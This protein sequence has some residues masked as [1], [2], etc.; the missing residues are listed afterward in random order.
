MNHQDRLQT[1]GFSILESAFE[2]RD[3]DRIIDELKVLPTSKSSSSR[4][5]RVFGARNLFQILPSLRSV[6]EAE[7]IT[8]WVRQLAGDQARS[9]RCLF[10]DKNPTANW[11]VGWHQDLTI[12]VRQRLP[13]E[14]F[15]PWTL[16]AGVPHVQPPVS[17]LE[18]ILTLRIHLDKTDES[19]GA[20]RVVSGSHRLGRL[21]PQMI[22]HLTAARNDKTCSVDAGGVLFM[23]PLLLHSSP[24]CKTP[25]HRRVLHVEFSADR[26]PGGLAW[27]GS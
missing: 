9:V 14:G 2:P 13:A 3:V 1:N 16:K 24:S 7:P 5:G 23:R 6:L 4:G 11:N 8:S 18:G 22:E 27:Y 26:L 20:L 25:A 15:G 10:F 21:S 19:N 17:I 12:A